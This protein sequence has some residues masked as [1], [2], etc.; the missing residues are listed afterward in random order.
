MKNYIVYIVCVFFTM[1]VSC[2]VAIEKNI[3]SK[4]IE[5]QIDSIFQKYNNSKTPGIAIGVV[6]KG[7]LIFSKEYGMANLGYD[8]P[9]S[10]STVFTLCSVS[11][12]FTVLGLMLLVEKDL[13][14]LNDDIRKYVPELPNYGHIITL[15]HL[16]NNTSGLRS[17]LQLLGL[18]GYTADDMI[19]QNTVDQVIFRQKELNFIPGDE[20]N[21][22]NSGFILLAKVIE[23]VSGKPFSSYIKENIFIPLGMHNS[24]VMDNYQKIVKNKAHSY[25]LGEDKS[26]VFS[27]SNYSYVGASGIYTTLEDFSKWAANFDSIKVG[28][29]DIFDQMNTK[30]VLNNGKESFYA[31][32]QIVQDYH[33]LK[34]IWHSGGDAGYR[35]Y[36]GRFPDQETTI[37]LLSNN[38]SVYAEG[39]ALKVANLFLKPFF[40]KSETKIKQE[41][42]KLRFINLS[43]KQKEKLT[44]SYLSKNYEII[45]N[46]QIQNDTLFYVRPN[47]GNRKSELKPINATK[48]VLGTNKDVQVSFKDKQTLKVLVNNEE[49]ESYYKYVPKVYTTED[50]QE[51]TGKYYCDE[52]EIIYELKVENNNLIIYN[53]KIG[54]IKINS[55]KEDVFIGTSWIFNS[56]VFERSK[57]KSVILG[58]RVSGQRVK[59][60]Y[61]KKL[62]KTSL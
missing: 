59:N 25:G 2:Q 56:L 3:N 42:Q 10:D 31:L 12:Q 37:I 54:T 29:Q 57:N 28:S 26:F 47:Q 11:K 43:L 52:L 39:E 62:K 51:F 46:I 13:I 38:A 16:A 34:R 24:F 61:F 19:T 22:S 9:V 20:Y 15:R 23:K 44:G 6:K 58:F 48:F 53:S 27:P 45:R 4:N 40:N 49:V 35:S 21:Y 32:G 30:G 50:L 33:G 41:N 1:H 7:E 14:S 8:I 60:M 18:K 55:L 36:I 5:K 17:N